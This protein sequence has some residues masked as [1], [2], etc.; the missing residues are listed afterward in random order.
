MFCSLFI[1]FKN[2]LFSTV[3]ELELA[4]FKGLLNTYTTLIIKDTWA[5]QDAL[6]DLNT[7]ATDLI[8]SGTFNTDQIVEKRDNV[9][10]RFLNVKE[11]AAEHH[12]KLKEA[13][14]L[15][16]FFQDLDDEEFWIEY[17]LIA[18]IAWIVQENR[19]STKFVL[20]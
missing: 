20:T 15:F 12:E 19:Q 4:V 16:Q 10:E 14:T 8:S 18:H 6:Q 1:I 9:N 3:F 17:V 11:L 7:L 2:D 13:Y 5:F